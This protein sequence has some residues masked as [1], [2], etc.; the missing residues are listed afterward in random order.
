M[1][2]PLYMLEISDDLMDDAEVQFVSLVDR[3]AIQK[4]WNAFKNE[5]KFQIISEDKHIISGCAMLADTPIFRSDATFGDYYVAFSKDTI[6]KIV[7]K[8]FKKGYQNNV[9]LMHDPNQIETGVTMFESFISDKSRGIPP[10]VGFEDAPDGSWFCSMLVENDAVW[11]Q[12]KEGKINGFSIEGIFNYAP[13]VSQE[14]QTMSE[15]YKILSEVDFG[16]VGSGRH[17]EGGSTNDNTSTDAAASA[18]AAQYAK[19]AQASVAKLMSSSSLDTHKLYQDKE[20]NYNPER[21]AFHKSIVTDKLSQ[22]STNLGTSFFLGGAPATGKSSLEKSGQVVY[23]QG[24]LRV[25]P[26]NIK[27]SLPEYN[28]M[29]SSKIPEAAAKVHE[30][31]SKI[32]KDVIHNASSNKF[33]AV[34]D[35]VGDGTFEKVAE[36]AQQQKD[37][38]KRVIAHY[39]TTDVQTSLDRAQHRATQTGRTVPADYIKDMHKE[40]STIFPK[41][42]ANNTFNELHLYDNNGT[43]PKLIYSKKDGKE[44]ILDKKAYKSFLDKAKG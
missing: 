31:S 8:Y 13:K 33:D 5:Q 43:S 19:D 41:L 10:M 32:T 36:K 16:G 21:T 15:I 11:Q 6:T 29:T 24:I 25:D 44:T 39:V 4:N 40:I 9:N 20:G 14:S 22:G 34:I 26:D 23:P 37:A 30:E 17:P 27:A 28:H 12:V 18:I 38:G 7:Q 35:T 42:A 1:E 3:P 2:L